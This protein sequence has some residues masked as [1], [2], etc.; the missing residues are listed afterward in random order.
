MRCWSSGH[1]ST[2]IKILADYQPDA[3][4]DLD[5]RRYLQTPYESQQRHKC[6]TSGNEVSETLSVAENIFRQSHV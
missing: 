1:K 2:L 4:S 6:S 5:G 3:Y